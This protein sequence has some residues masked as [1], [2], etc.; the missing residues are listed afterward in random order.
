MAKQYK[1]E[2][3]REYD[4]E[5]RCGKCGTR[6]LIVLKRMP[7]YSVKL[8]VVPCKLHPEE[9]VILWPQREDLIHE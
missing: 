8:T 1:H 5:G 9:S 4:F 2:G 3:K 6:L 7:P